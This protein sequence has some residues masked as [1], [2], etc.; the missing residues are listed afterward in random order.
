MLAPCFGVGPG[1]RSNS[2]GTTPDPRFRMPSPL[3]ACETILD[4]D[5]PGHGL[6]DGDRD[7]SI[8]DHDGLAHP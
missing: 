3:Q 7:P 4:V 8:R 1:V 5:A 2:T 6:D